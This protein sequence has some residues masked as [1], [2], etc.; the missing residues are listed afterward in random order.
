M[1]LLNEEPGSEEA[2]AKEGKGQE[3]EDH[4]QA[5]LV[6]SSE[7]DFIKEELQS[8]LPEGEQEKQKNIKHEQLKLEVDGNE[9][10]GK[11]EPAPQKRGDSVTDIYQQNQPK[12][13]GD[14]KPVI[15]PSC[16]QSEFKRGGIR[17]T[18]KLLRDLCKQ[19]KLYMTPALNDTLYLHY[20]ASLKVLHTLQIA[21]NMLETV[22]DIQHLQECP[23][24]SVLDLSHNR[25]DDPNILDVLETMPD[26]RVLNLMGN[27]VI[28]K[29]ANYRRTLTIRLK[30]L[31]YLDDRPVFPKDRACAE[32]WATGGREAEKKERETWETKERKKIQNSIDALTAIREKAK[33]KKR[34][35]EM[36]ERKSAL[37]GQQEGEIPCPSNNTVTSNTVESLDT[38]ENSE[39]KQ[40]IEKFVRESM[41]A[42]EESLAAAENLGDQLDRSEC[43][44]VEMSVDKIATPGPMLTE[45]PDPPHIE[46][47]KL[48]T[49][50]Q[51]FLDELPDLEDVDTSEAFVEEESFIRKQTSPP[52]IE[53]ISEAN[54]DK[55]CIV[56][57][58]T[59]ISGNIV[60]EEIPTSIFSNENKVPEAGSKEALQ[61]IIADLLIQEKGEF[62]SKVH[63]DRPP[64]PLIEEITPEPL[65]PSWI[66]SL[67]NEDDTWL[68]EKEEK[69]SLTPPQG[70]LIHALQRFDTGPSCLLAVLRA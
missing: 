49:P 23:S 36:E 54:E 38:L 53:V 43:S 32:A 28:K 33:E 25:L 18:K 55:D 50:E 62:E 7:N 15:D 6:P 61:P 13:N 19:H 22:E 67:C 14:Q 41:D 52:K 16:E 39:T 5:N 60:T 70:K 12:T 1:H 2:V 29:I 42:H 63:P 26:L 37:A 11:G 34:Q 44:H 69:H 8:Q 4:G 64:R 51:L 58:T 46:E 31:T 9:E 20:K 21:H 59:L 17:M 57:G 40:K 56:E 24:I 48:E 47:I 27:D 10:P 68:V 45:L 3:A 66:L 65:D 30:H 35:R